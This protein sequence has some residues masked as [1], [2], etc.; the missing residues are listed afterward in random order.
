M[1][2]QARSNFAYKE[3]VAALCGKMELPIPVQSLFVETFLLGHSRPLF[4]YF[5]L[6]NTVYN[7]VDSK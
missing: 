4:L 6:F 1:K 5:C 2:C 3:S 7:T